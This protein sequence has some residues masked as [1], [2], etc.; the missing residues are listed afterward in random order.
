MRVWILVAALA[1]S[2]SL[3]AAQVLDSIRA[4]ELAIEMAEDIRSLERI[5]DLQFIS[6]YL[7]EIGAFFGI[8]FE[9]P[10]NQEA[11]QGRTK[12]HL[13][14]IYS[15]YGT[16]ALLEEAARL[17]EERG[18]GW[19]KPLA[20]EKIA[21]Q[22]GP[23]VAL[24]AAR[25]R[26]LLESA[27]H[28]LMNGAGLR[29]LD[30]VLAWLSSNDLEPEL[31]LRL[32]RRTLGFGSHYEPYRFWQRADS[33]PEPHRTRVR[34]QA[35]TSTANA[36]TIPEGVLEAELPNVAEVAATLEPAES[37]EAMRA[38]AVACSRRQM[39]SCSTLC[40]SP[41]SVSTTV[42]PNMARMTMALR[43]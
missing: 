6:H 2:P 33:L 1:A 26:D 11:V 4:H 34:I 15:E 39:K 20:L 18:V 40:T 30:E 10:A 38:I 31:H 12:A 23:E 22:E 42:P 5:S 28:Q 29:R 9:F 7:P 13:D 17:D 24:Q 35:L 8:E 19:W 37:R 27:F 32:R 41:M 25:E 21:R 36:E 14:V 3:L 43:P 16:Q